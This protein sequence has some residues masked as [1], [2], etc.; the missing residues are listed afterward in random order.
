M[1]TVASKVAAGRSVM[2]D[3]TV[4]A[5]DLEGEGLGV[6]VDVEVVV[7]PAGP[8]VV[9]VTD[10]PEGVDTDVTV[11][12]EGEDTAGQHNCRIRFPCYT[13]NVCTL[14]SVATAVSLLLKEEWRFCHTLERRR[15]TC[16]PCVA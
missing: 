10:E 1:N 8:L 15:V 4:P 5:L 2:A 11:V 12:G 9:V 14:C 6:A 3:R 7:E 16:V 13:K